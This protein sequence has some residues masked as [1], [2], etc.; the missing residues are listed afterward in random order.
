MN[1]PQVQLLSFPFQLVSFYDA[2]PISL[3]P[4]DFIRS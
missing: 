3:V 4:A 2:Q 1:Y